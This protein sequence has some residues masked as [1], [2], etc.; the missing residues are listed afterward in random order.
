MISVSNEFKSV[1]NS[2]IRN[3][4]VEI[5]TDA[6]YYNP[7]NIT[8]YGNNI[9]FGESYYET[10]IVG[11]FNNGSFTPSYPTIT[12]SFNNEIYIS[13]VILVFP[14][15][16]YKYLH[17]NYKYFGGN[18]TTKQFTINKETDEIKIEILSGVPN[19]T[20]KISQVIFYGENDELI[21]RDIPFAN[22]DSEIIID[23]EIEESLSLDNSEH[24]YRQLVFQLLP[25]E[26][27]TEELIRKKFSYKKEVMVNYCLQTTDGNEKCL[28]GIF[29]VATVG[30]NYAN[31]TI[32][33][34]C[35]D[36][37]YFLNEPFY[38]TTYVPVGVE[39]TGNTNIPL[40]TFFNQID[41]RNLLKLDVNIIY[42]WL[43][44]WNWKQG[45]S[46]AKNLYWSGFIGYYSSIKEMLRNVGQL[47]GIFI[48]TTRDNDILLTD[49]NNYFL[50]SNFGY[51]KKYT[52]ISP[53]IIYSA[54][55]QTKENLIQ[56]VAFNKRKFINSSS[57]TK[58]IVNLQYNAETFES[59]KINDELIIKLENAVVPTT[60][61]YDGSTTSSDIEILIKSP[62]YVKIKILKSFL[63]TIQLKAVLLVDFGETNYSKETDSS[64]SKETDI[65][66]SLNW[67][68][69]THEEGKQSVIA[70][71]SDYIINKQLSA[72]KE[73]AYEMEILLQPYL[74]VGDL[75]VI[76]NEQG[77]N[78]TF[79][80][81]KNT[82]SSSLI[83]K[84]RLE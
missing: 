28:L 8:H 74:E 7:Y 4:S 37:L 65:S 55:K 70:Y 77:E 76:K 68:L 13:K 69:R 71:D 58:N 41:L 31:K 84:I 20:L 49:A 72:Y 36:E 50:D 29:K 24:S 61:D 54:E 81:T 12:Y 14:T 45:Y 27:M 40:T 78:E 64:Y 53:K 21:L 83:Q 63:T 39:N 82:I 44:F 10:T 5:S 18:Q 9:N 48:K 11:S 51:I 59:P 30:K 56:K 67:V 26:N 17:V 22:I 33:I 52:Y 46:Y 79:T 43:S 73:T 25:N 32:E 2:N 6:N 1:C 62:E 75:V 3:S 35:F 23:Y 42:L 38:G 19:K 16:E 15:D 34:T 66:S 57:A 80:I 60:I 47:F